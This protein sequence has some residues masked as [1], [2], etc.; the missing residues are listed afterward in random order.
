[1]DPVGRRNPR[2]LVVRLGSAVIT[3]GRAAACFG[4][5]SSL[6]VDFVADDVVAVDVVA[7]DVVAVDVV[8]D[9]VVA[10]DVVADVVTCLCSAVIA[11]DSSDVI[12]C[13]CSAVIVSDSSDVIACL[14]SAVIASDSSDVIACLC[15]AVITG[16]R[17]AAC[18]GVTCL[19][20]AG[21]SDV[22]DCLCSAAVWLRSGVVFSLVSPVEML[23][24]MFLR[25]FVAI[26]SAGGRAASCSDVVCL[27]SAGVSVVSDL[28]RAV[29]SFWGVSIAEGV[30]IA[31]SSAA[32]SF[33]A[34][35]AA[36]VAADS[37]AFLAA[38]CSSQACSSVSAAAAAGEAGIIG[39]W[40]WGS[41]DSWRAADDGVIAGRSVCLGGEVL[42]PPCLW[43]ASCSTVSSHFSPGDP[44]SNRAERGAL[45][46]I[47]LLC[48]QLIRLNNTLR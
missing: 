8:A 10:D 38:I 23:L 27:C 42:R 11:S 1:M 35:A 31:A 13:L 7:D 2:E 36:A 37:S 34:A 19:C 32:S 46:S 26:G 45:A 48:S 16:G 14:C 3:G 22:S 25:V 5:T 20:S 40:G 39:A 47:E 29:I 43:A 30:S 9:D 28:R 15:S 18:F 24:K 17:A 21:I 6:S 4:S 33:E 12:A 41:V 44:G